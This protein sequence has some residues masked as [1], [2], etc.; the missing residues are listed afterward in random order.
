[1][2]LQNK[3]ILLIS[4]EPWDHIFVSKHHY[5]IHLAERGNRVFFLN[6]PK[7]FDGVSETDHENVFLINYSGFSPGLRFYPTILQK[8]FIRRKFNAFQK[9]C[10]V[11][12]DVVWSFDNS[13]F[14]N[15][16][17]LPDRVLKICHIVD[18]NQDF[19][20]GIA[21]RTANYCF[22][23]TELIKKRLLQF[24]PRVF[25]INHGFNSRL[26]NTTIILPGKSKIKAL[27]AGNLAIPFIDWPLLTL[28]VEA[29]P[30]VDFIFIGPGKEHAT[31]ENYIQALQLKKNVFFPGR[32]SSNELNKYYRASDILLICY[33]DKFH[34]TQANVHKMMEY[35]GSGKVII[36][37]HTA[38][39]D[40]LA[41]D[42][43]IAMSSQNKAFMDLFSDTLK[44]LT[45]WNASDKQRSRMMF[46]LDN[47]YEMQIRRI[48]GHLYQ[49][50]T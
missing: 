40:A 6:P 38:E 17:A 5:A 8:Y 37:T 19:Q 3:N 1:M 47:T 23:T 42:S 13:V 18:L 7:R 24:N 34:E 31:I 43:L 30:D 4:P 41:E 33:K 25:K 49:K 39:Y 32:I 16:S 10:N 20:T 2:R 9:Q 35:L 29:Q 15:F 12:F 27:Y 11:E 48:E 26:D 14:Y 44:N 50:E 28:L 45:Y 21:A 46:A 22:C 36:A